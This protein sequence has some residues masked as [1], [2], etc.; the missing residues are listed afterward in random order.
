[1][2]EYLKG[3]LTY[4]YPTALV[5]DVQGVGYLV[6]TANPFSFSSFLNQEV[7][8]YCYQAVREDAITLYGFHNVEEKQ[9]FLKLI[10][11]SGIGPKSALAILAN[12]DSAG[13]IQAIENDD[14]AYLTK[15]PGVGK[16]TA[17]QLVLDLKGKLADITPSQGTATVSEYHVLEDTKEALLGLGYSNKEIQKIWPSLEKESI[18]DTADALRIAFKLLLTVKK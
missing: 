15:F 16:K 9:L 6:Q 8:V 11:V 14:V 17:G 18:V 10:S 2:Y 13:L 4:I 1:M 12:Q 5:V 7:S 3:V